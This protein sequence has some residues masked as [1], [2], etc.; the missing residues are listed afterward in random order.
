MRLGGSTKG[1]ASPKH[2]ADGIAEFWAWWVTARPEIEAAI[3]ANAPERYEPDLTVAVHRIHPGL[4]WEVGGRDGDYQLVVTACGRPEPR[5][6]AARW[7][8]AAPSERSG[9]AF[10]ATRQPDPAALSLHLNVDSG[11]GKL[12]MAGLSVAVVEDEQS[13]RVHVA[14]H[15]DGFAALADAQRLDIAYLALDWALGEQDVQRWIGEVSTVAELPDAAIPIASLATTVA[16]F[17]ERHPRAFALVGATVEGLP[18]TAVVQVPLSP[19]D[20]PLFDQHIAVAV[21]YAA[22]NAGRLQVGLSAERIRAFD[23]ALS[24]LVG[25][26]A[27]LAVAVSHDGRRVFHYYTDPLSSVAE[28]VAAWDHGWPEGR[29]DI[30]VSSD[31]AWNAVRPFQP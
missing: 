27:V 8:L 9:W 11:A 10:H 13:W 2:P 6:A 28:R 30:Q 19:V 26:D 14:V 24:G 21:P 5:S 1:S 22:M 7:L 18:L 12:A 31:P 17:A 29:V 15:H 20:F 25:D 3:A 16:G 4:Q 23:D